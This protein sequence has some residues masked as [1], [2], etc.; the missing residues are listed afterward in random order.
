MALYCVE[1]RLKTLLS[2][3]SDPDLESV[4]LIYAPWGYGTANDAIVAQDDPHIKTMTL[5]EFTDWLATVS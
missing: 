3:E 5:Q 1:D 2:V 4:K